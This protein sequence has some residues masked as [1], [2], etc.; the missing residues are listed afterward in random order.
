MLLHTIIYII[1]NIYY[2]YNIMYI[3]TIIYICKYTNSTLSS[4]YTNL[5]RKQDTVFVTNIKLERM[6]YG[7]LSPLSSFFRKA[8]ILWNRIIWMLTISTA[9]QVSKHLWIEIRIWLYVI[10]SETHLYFLCESLKVQ[11]VK[12]P[13]IT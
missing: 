4:V 5:G 12:A 6:A 1:Y 2:I 9:Y 11:V 13:Y 7:W 8:M 3:H 10:I